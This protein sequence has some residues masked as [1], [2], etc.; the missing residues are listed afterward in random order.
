M[1]EQV[2]TEFAI[3]WLSPDDIA[4]SIT[5]TGLGL[6]GLDKAESYI[7][8]SARLPGGQRGR[9]LSRTITWSD[10]KVEVDA[11]A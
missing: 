9:I 7:R 4:G 2:V 5:E 6:H 11:Q 10:W 3:E 8:T 1:A